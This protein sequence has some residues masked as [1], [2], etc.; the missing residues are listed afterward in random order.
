MKKLVEAILYDKTGKMLFAYA[1]STKTIKSLAG[2]KRIA[3]LDDDAYAQVQL[4]DSIVDVMKSYAKA[5][6]DSYIA[7]VDHI[8]IYNDY[9]NTVNK[10]TL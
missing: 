10:Y 5:Y 4:E 1:L 8:L 3:E 9:A 6:T 7:A 2:I